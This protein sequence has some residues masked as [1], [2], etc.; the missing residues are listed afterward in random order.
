[1]EHQDFLRLDKTTRTSLIIAMYIRNELE[2]FH[3]NHLTDSQM[4]ELNPIIRQ[5]V[6]NILTYLKLAGSADVAALKIID[7]QIMLIPD[8]WELPCKNPPW[9]ELNEISKFLN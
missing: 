2:D 6:F 9:K 3:S 4:K 5:A 1:M 8:Y 7:Y